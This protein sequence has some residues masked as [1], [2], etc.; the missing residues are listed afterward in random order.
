MRDILETPY[1]NFEKARME[2][3]AGIPSAGLAEMIIDKE[4]QLNDRLT[5]R[6]QFAMAAL[7]GTLAAN[8]GWGRYKDLAELSYKIADVMLEARKMVPDATAEGA[9][10]EA[11]APT[12]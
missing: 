7:Q 4:R 1:S 9:Y 8:V 12:S 11:Q 5:P 6:D 3:L 10:S 2:A